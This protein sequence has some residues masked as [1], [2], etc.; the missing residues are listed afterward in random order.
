MINIGRL[1]KQKNQTEIIE[2]LSNVKKK[3]QFRL[4]I[5]GQGPEKKNLNNLIEKKKLKN[6]VKISDNQKSKSFYLKKSDIFVLSSL[7]EG[8]PNVLLEAALNKKY[9]ISSNCPT[10]PKELIKS[11]KYGALYKKN[12]YNHLSKVFQ[13]IA[14]DRKI[15]FKK[16]KMIN[17]N[18]IIFDHKYNLE[19][20]KKELLNIIN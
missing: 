16:K 12:S 18:S 6:L 11:Y 15:L 9:I 2:A 3:E 5:I 19:K 17:L 20:Y 4:L 8:F 13:K 14:D 10:G 1:V 7:Y